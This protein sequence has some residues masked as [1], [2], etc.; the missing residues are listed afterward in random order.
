MIVVASLM[1]AFDSTEFLIA[2][3]SK[4]ADVVFVGAVLTALSV[5]HLVAAVVT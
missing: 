1:F 4:L 3:E 5:V 2:F